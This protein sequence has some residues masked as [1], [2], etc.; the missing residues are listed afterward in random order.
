VDKDYRIVKVEKS[1]DLNVWRVFAW[2]DCFVEPISQHETFAEATRA[3]ERY[4]DNDRRRR[5]AP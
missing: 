5:S 4:R 1:P 2:D 3:V